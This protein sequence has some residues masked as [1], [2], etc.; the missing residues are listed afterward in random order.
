MTQNARLSL[1]SQRQLLMFFVA[2]G[3]L[4]TYLQ[5][6]SEAWRGCMARSVSKILALGVQDDWVGA[7]GA[8]GVQLHCICPQGQLC[9]LTSAIAAFACT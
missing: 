7:V 6:S 1:C 5:A 4:I 2:S 9:L 8:E 3:K